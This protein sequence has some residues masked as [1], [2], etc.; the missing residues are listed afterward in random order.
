MTCD[1]FDAELY[2]KGPSGRSL[3]GGSSYVAMRRTATV[4]LQRNKA[5]VPGETGYREVQLDKEQEM[6]V[7]RRYRKAFQERV[8]DGGVA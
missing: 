7:S 6:P 8:E 3:G 4:N 1:Y 2:Q 5:L